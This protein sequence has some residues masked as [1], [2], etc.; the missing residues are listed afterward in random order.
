MGRQRKWNI[1]M[2]LEVQDP[3]DKSTFSSKDL[4]WTDL[5]RR[6]DPLFDNIARIPLGI[7]PDFSTGEERNLDA[8]CTFLHI[9]KK[10][11]TESDNSHKLYEL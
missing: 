9:L 11:P 6:D 10:K 1:I 7:I 8:P 4:T 2:A 3:K 5:Y